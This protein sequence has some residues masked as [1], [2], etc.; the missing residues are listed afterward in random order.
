VEKSESPWIP[1]FLPSDVLIDVAR[2]G[3]M[4]QMDTLGTKSTDLVFLEEHD[5][6]LTL[7]VFNGSKFVFSDIVMGHS[8]GL[9]T[10]IQ[11][12]ESFEQSQIPAIAIAAKDELLI[13][14][15][16]SSVFSMKLDPVSISEVESEY[17]NQLWTYAS[18]QDQSEFESVV[19]KIK[20]S[21]GN[22][23]LSNQ[24]QRF[25]SIASISLMQDY[26]KTNQVNTNIQ[27]HISAIDALPKRETTD[28]FA[29]SIIVLGTLECEI[30]LLSPPKY[31]VSDRFQLSSAV[32]HLK[33]VGS[34]FG[35]FKIFALCMDGC[36]Y[37]ISR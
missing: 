25:L 33:C 37:L 34:Y 2:S 35:D 1:I 20:D 22:L 28:G 4:L 31:I 24:M 16:S 21:R 17:W 12:A 26:V 14:H 36:V 15:R 27:I 7:K 29:P 6:Y 32:L 18:S 11:L 13:Y 3:N 8:A 19:N 30:Y 23:L 9:L 10:S 5:N